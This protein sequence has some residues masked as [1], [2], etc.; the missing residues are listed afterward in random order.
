MTDKFFFF[1][2]FGFWLT[3]SLKSMALGSILGIGGKIYGIPT[4]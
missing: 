2:A 1:L 4:R 3:E